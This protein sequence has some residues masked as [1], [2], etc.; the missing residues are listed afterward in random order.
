[1]GTM[2][3]V[4][5]AI[6]MAMDEEM[7]RD[8]DVFL[9]GEEV[10]QYNGAYKVSKGLYHKYGDKRVIDTPITEMGFAGLTIGAAYKGLKPICEFMTFNFSLQAIDQVIN[11]AAKQLYMSAGDIPV[12]IVFRGPNGAAAAVAAQHS[13]CFAAWYGS[14]P[15]L[16][17]VCPWDSKDA[18]GLLK[19]AIRDPNPVVVL[20]NEMLYGVE[21]EMSDAEMRDDF[22]L[23]L[24]K[25]QIVKEGTDVTIVAFARMVGVA[26]EAADALAAQGVNAEVINMRCIRPLDRDTLLA[27]VTKTHRLVTVEEGWPQSGVGAEMAACVFESAAFDY[28]DAPVERI[29]GADVPMPYA[30]N[31]ETLAKPQ[32][33]NIVNAALRAVNRQM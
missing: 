28:L 5:E 3:P 18:K 1:M 30:I 25:A 24:D 32:A 20:E 19:S 16:K 29:T 21:F 33:Q 17:V 7:A 6:N 12:P 14:V 8:K 23:P 27:S 11:S 4:R 15:G 22:L 13:Q 31:L 10:A 26:M 2:V 9:M